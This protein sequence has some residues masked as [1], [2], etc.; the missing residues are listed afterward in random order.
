MWSTGEDPGRLVVE[1]DVTGG[2]IEVEVVADLLLALGA[3]AVSERPGGDTVVI[4]ADLAPDAVTA[5]AALGHDARVVEPDPSWR[6]AWRDGAR[7]V[8]VGRLLVRPPWVPADA[9]VPAGTVEVQVDPGDAFGSGAHP[10]TLGCLAEVD[11][12]VRPGDRVLDVGSG[13]G[14]LGVAAL[15]LGA[16]SVAAVDTDEEAL[17]VTAAVAA[18]NGVG[19]RLSVGRGLSEVAGPFELVLANLLV[20]VV[21]ELAPALRDA[22]GPLGHLVVGGV[23]GP[24][25]GRVVDAVG[26]GPLRVVAA[27]GQPADGWTTVVFGPEDLSPRP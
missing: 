14:V 21:E 13:S 2:P 15:R 22:T 1:L 27:P 18:A 12:L 9:D 16:G 6:T 19:G 10:T 26:P 3:S 7:A 4:C 25:V 8:R 11:R 5:L 17:R 24:Q 23:L 20:D